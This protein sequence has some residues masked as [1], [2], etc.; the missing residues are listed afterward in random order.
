MSAVFFC[1][2][3]LFA[4]IP[5]VRSSTL[6]CSTVVSFHGYIIFQCKALPQVLIYL[7]L[8]DTELFWLGDSVLWFWCSPFSAPA[9]I[10]TCRVYSLEWSCW[11]TTGQFILRFGRWCQMIFLNVPNLH[12]NPQGMPFLFSSYPPSS[13]YLLINPCLLTVSGWGPGLCLGL[14]RLL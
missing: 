1:I 11:V 4:N 8:V 13:I 10:S 6:L 7:L 3:L 9:S 14:F 2:R 5:L 12:S